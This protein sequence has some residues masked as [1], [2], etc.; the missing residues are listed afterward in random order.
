LVV[1]RKVLAGQ[2][3]HFRK[4]ADSAK[5]LLAVGESPRDAKLDAADHAA[6]TALV[7]AL[8]NLDEA[9]TRE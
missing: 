2:R 7:S 4:D 5:K 8:F 9:L 1:L 3:E 6:M